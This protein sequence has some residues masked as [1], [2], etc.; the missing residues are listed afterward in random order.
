MNIKLFLNTSFKFKP[1]A[2][3]KSSNGIEA[4]FDP[5]QAEAWAFFR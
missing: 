1:P 5:S 3:K 2:T 4:S